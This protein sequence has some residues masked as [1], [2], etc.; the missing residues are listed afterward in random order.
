MW[1]ENVTLDASKGPGQDGK[2]DHCCGPHTISKTSQDVKSVEDW[3][4]AQG[5]PEKHLQSL[6]DVKG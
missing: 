5:S 2:R 1:R 3:D 4:A 6:S